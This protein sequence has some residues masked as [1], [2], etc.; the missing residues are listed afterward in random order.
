MKDQKKDLM[1]ENKIYFTPG[2]R[3]TLKQNIP[4][5][6]I[7]VIIKKETRTFKTEDGN[8][9]LRGMRCIWFTSNGELQENVFNTKD[10]IIVE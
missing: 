2:M 3:V 9:L 1:E 8:S 6:P 5:K 4:N 10:L 7:M